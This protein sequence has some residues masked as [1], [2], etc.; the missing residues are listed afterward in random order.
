MGLMLGEFMDPEEPGGLQSTGSQRVD[1]TEA[2]LAHTR[3]Q[4]FSRGLEGQDTIHTACCST[5][6]SICTSRCTAQHHFF[7]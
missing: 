1:T 4:G 2:A 7:F 5:D 3:V 6:T